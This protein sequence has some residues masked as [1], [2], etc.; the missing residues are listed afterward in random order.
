MLRKALSETLGDSPQVP[1][2]TT[3]TQGS[4]AQVLIELSDGADLLVV[5]HVVSAAL[6]AC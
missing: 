5:G 2:N 4:P 1:V 6:P 3:V